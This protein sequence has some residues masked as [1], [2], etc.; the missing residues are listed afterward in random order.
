MPRGAYH[1]VVRICF[2][3]ATIFL[4][5]SP[6]FRCHSLHDL[7]CCFASRRPSGQSLLDCITEHALAQQ[8]DTLVLQARHRRPAACAA[9]AGSAACRHSQARCRQCKLISCTGQGH[10]SAVVLPC[11]GSAYDVLSQRCAPSL[12]NTLE[13]A[14]CV[15]SSSGH[16]ELYAL[17]TQSLPASPRWQHRGSAASAVGHGHAWCTLSSSR[18]VR[19]CH[20]FDSRMAAC[21]AQHAISFVWCCGA[22]ARAYS[23]AS[24]DQAG[25]MDSPPASGPAIECAPDAGSGHQCL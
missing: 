25:V 16:L 10:S 3:M 20:V 13:P 1:R 11:M 12:L 7:G 24:S 5:P 21:R 2:D 14:G 15:L 9:Q 4:V 18:H 8:V 6:G 22:P 19:V 17:F 23:I